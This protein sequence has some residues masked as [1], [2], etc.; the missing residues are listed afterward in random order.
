MKAEENPRNVEE[1]ILPQEK[2]RDEHLN[3]LRKAL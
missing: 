3:K 2:K 1:I